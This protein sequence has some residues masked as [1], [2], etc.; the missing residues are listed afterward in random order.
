MFTSLYILT[1]NPNF[2]FENVMK[3]RFMSLLVFSIIFHTVVYTIF[4]N[5]VSYI[6]YNR[7]LSRSINAR[8]VTVLLFIMF[9]GYIGRIL[10][11]KEIYKSFNYDEEKT[12]AYINQ[13][14]NSWIF[15]G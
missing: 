12:M 15:A 8:L 3:P 1:T 4:A 7:F 10:H 14:Y 9:F 6:F 2:K 13:H 5:S 11:V